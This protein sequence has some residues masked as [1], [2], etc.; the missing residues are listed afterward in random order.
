MCYPGRHLLWLLCR[1][2]LLHHPS[3]HQRHHII[4]YLCCFILHLHPTSFLIKCNLLN[5]VQSLTCFPASSP[6]IASLP[7][8]T[9]LHRSPQTSLL[10]A[11]LLTQLNLTFTHAG[12]TLPLIVSIILLGPERKRLA[13]CNATKPPTFTHRPKQVSLHSQG[14]VSINFQ[15]INSRLNEPLVRVLLVISFVS[16]V[17]SIAAP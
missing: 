6:R 10:H 13:T 7:H 12:T 3:H 17:L 1:S 2:Y 11:A 14:Q 8:L 9:L 16:G 4:S 15:I 5:A